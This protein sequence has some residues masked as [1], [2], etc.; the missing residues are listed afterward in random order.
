[1]RQ[2]FVLAVIVTI[3]CTS[4]TTTEEVRTGYIE[5]KLS[6]FDPQEPMWKDGRNQGYIYEQWIREPENLETVYETLKKIGLRKLIDQE[7]RFSTISYY[8]IDIRKPMNELLDSLILTYEQN[9]IFSTYYREF[10]SR[11]KSENNE[12]TVYQILTD[13]TS[14]L[15]EDH[16]TEP[17]ESLV[18]D[19]LYNLVSM[20][21]LP[22][23][24]TLDLA[25][26][27]FEYLTNIGMHQSAYNLLFESYRYSHLNWNRGELRERLTVD[28]VNC[29]PIPWIEDDTK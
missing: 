16:F 25:R 5:R 6:F 23:S 27:H 24:I 29:C 22:D 21:E 18:N 15:Y 8:G 14:E 9:T 19:T 13:L 10:W 17:N 28:S 3:S 26:D 7:R 1:M 20:R 12:E 4:G 2:I 11:R